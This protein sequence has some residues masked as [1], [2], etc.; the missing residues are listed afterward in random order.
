[1]VVKAD[2]GNKHDIECGGRS[3]EAYRELAW[4]Y[5]PCLLRYYSCTVGLSSNISPEGYKTSQ[6]GAQGEFKTHAVRARLCVDRSRTSADD[7]VIG[8][9]DR[10]TCFN[11]TTQDE[12][13]K[14]P[15]SRHQ[16]TAD[17]SI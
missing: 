3:A 2:L 14:T 13:S 17:V 1:M 7:P 11:A 8:N 9:G 12:V 10:V 16:N 4:G 15:S 5:N 6:T